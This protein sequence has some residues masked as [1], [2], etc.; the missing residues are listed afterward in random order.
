MPQNA[1]FTPLDGRLTS[2]EV[3]NIALSGDEVMEIVSPGNAEFGNNFQV[4]TANLAGFFASFPFQFRTVITTGATLASPYPIAI[5][6]TQILFDK[7]IASDSYAVAPLASAMQYPFP[8]LIKDYN[9]AAGANPITIS[10]TGGELCDGLT[11]L[12][13]S[14]PYGWVRINPAPSGGAWYQ[15]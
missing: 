3:L 5:T 6:D 9:G 8:V 2:L 15:S 11:N 7:L 14:N 10:F 1:T 12:T 4:T 13:I